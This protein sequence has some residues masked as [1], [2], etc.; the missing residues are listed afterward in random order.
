VVQLEL[1]LETEGLLIE[2]RTSH[3]SSAGQ[4]QFRAG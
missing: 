1:L 4:N 3:A 2:E